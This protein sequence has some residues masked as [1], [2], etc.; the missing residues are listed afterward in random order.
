MR[1]KVK[2]LESDKLRSSG[3]QGFLF[4]YCRMKKYIF[5]LSIDSF[6]CSVDN[7]TTAI[8]KFDTEQ[9]FI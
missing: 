8:F 6:S 7:V 9:I 5:L 1:L 2:T 3:F 4:V